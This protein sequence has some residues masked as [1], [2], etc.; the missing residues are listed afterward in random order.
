MV[1]DIS[2]KVKSYKCFRNEEQGFEKIYPINI[3]IGK[4][5]SGKSSLIDL[6][7]YLT[8]PATGV[9][10][11]PPEEGWYIIKFNITENVVEEAIAKYESMQ[12]GKTG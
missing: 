3:I 9:M 12:P 1:I 10:K 11:I 5:N 6:I 7:K 4:N 2:I 8:S